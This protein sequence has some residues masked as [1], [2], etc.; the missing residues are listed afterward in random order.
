MSLSARLQ[1]SWYRTDGKDA[2]SWALLDASW[3]YRGLVALRKK[4]YASGVLHSTRLPVPVIVVGNVIA[5]GSGKT[6]IVI[7][8]AKW[9]NR[10]GFS[11][12]I[13]SR[14]YGRQGSAVLEVTANTPISASGDEPALIRSA[15]SAPVFVGSDRAEAAQALLAAYPQTQ[16]IL[17]DDGLQHLALQRDIEICVF[18]ERGVGNGRLLPAGPLREPWPRA[19]PNAREPWPRAVDFILHRGGFESAASPSFALQRQLADHALAFDGSRI[20]L[21]ELQQPD[22][23]AL[24]G[25]AEPEAFFSMLRERGV[26]LQETLALPDHNDFD[27]VPRGIHEGQTL[28]CTEKDAVKLWKMPLAQKCRILAVP[29]VVTLPEGFY[30]ALLEKLSSLQAQN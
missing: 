27:S 12:G 24:A 7:E 17:S 3:F 8:L 6:P 26:A 2:L 14:G 10:I 1:K 25:I 11:V 20:A 30:S 5:G 13:V 23:I 29:L 15:Q 28:I 22:Q 4:M 18:D 21:T 9:L 16:V 19:F